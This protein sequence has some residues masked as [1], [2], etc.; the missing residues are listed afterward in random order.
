MN[1]LLCDLQICGGVR[2]LQQPHTRSLFLFPMVFIVLHWFLPL[3]GRTLKLEIRSFV[4][5][6]VPFER[7]ETK[8]VNFL[9]MES[10]QPL[11]ISAKSANFWQGP[12]EKGG[13]K[14]ANCWQGKCEL[15]EK[16]S[17]TLVTSL[18]S[19]SVSHRAH[20]HH[21]YQVL[22]RLVYKE[23]LQMTELDMSICDKTNGQ[24][25]LAVCTRLHA[26]ER[27][28]SVN[29]SERNWLSTEP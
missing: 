1:A 3:M 4:F 28:I 9:A 27:H 16:F 25:S 10:V 13:M 6:S 18:S 15:I 17:A 7:G 5:R 11:P 22:L 24:N 12:F 19:L 20:N 29:A 21:Q 8:S 2:H 14:S 26:T 23:S